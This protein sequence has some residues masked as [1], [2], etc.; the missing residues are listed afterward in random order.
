MKDALDKDLDYLLGNI[1]KVHAKQKAKRQTRLS[2]PENQESLSKIKLNMTVA[3]SVCKA[4][5][6]AKLTQAQLAEKL[7]TR[8]SYIAEVE[9]GKRNITLESLENMAM[10]CGK[11]VELRFV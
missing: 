6:N 4:R 8:E 1:D 5:K 9:K 3:E 2:A 11:H 10:A 7:H